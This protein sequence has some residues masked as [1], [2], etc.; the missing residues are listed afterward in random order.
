[1][2]LRGFL[3]PFDLVDVA[4]L[5]ER[6][7]SRRRRRSTARPARAALRTRPACESGRLPPLPPP[8]A[9]ISAWRSRDFADLL[10][11]EPRERAVCEANVAASLREA[12]RELLL[13]DRDAL[14]SRS[15]AGARASR[16]RSTR[17]RSRVERLGADA[18]RRR[19][20]RGRR[21]PSRRGA[22]R[23][24]RSRTGSRRRRGRRTCCRLPSG[25]RPRSRSLRGGL[26]LRGDVA[27]DALARAC[28]LP[29]LAAA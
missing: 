23:C 17:E 16:R 9:R 4:Q 22:C 21:G 28:S 5:L 29:R 11:I 8:V 14:R 13:R 26:L 15:S 24:L 27:A 1:M 25:T 20:R 10:R 3:R 19:D 12:A 18:A 2:R 6:A 7:P